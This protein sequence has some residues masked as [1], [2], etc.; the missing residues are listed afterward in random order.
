MAEFVVRVGDQDD[1]HLE[2]MDGLAERL[3][4]S[5]VRGPVI[6]YICTSSWASENMRGKVVGVESHDCRRDN[7][8]SL[9]VSE[10]GTVEYGRS[11]TEEEWAELNGRLPK[12]KDDYADGECPDCGESIPDGAW[13]GESCENC[14]HVFTGDVLVDD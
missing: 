12:V 7:Y 1:Y 13:T 11:I 8:I 5:R 2:D 9:F 6:P 10:D 14:G 3:R 4:M